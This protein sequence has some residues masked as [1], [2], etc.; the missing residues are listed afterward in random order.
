MGTTPLDIATYVVNPFAVPP[1]LTGA[2]F[3][4]L[5]LTT[6]VRERGSRTSWSFLAV[7]LAGWLWLTCFGFMYLAA[8]SVVAYFWAKAAYLGIPL[9][10]PALYEFA[11]RVLGIRERRRRLVL[12]NWVLFGGF[13]VAFVATDR[14]FGSLHL[15]PW[16]FYP[17]VEPAALAFVLT[18]VGVIGLALSE[19]RRSYRDAETETERLR[20]RALLIAFGVGALALLDY[21]PGFGVEMYPVGFVPALAFLAITANA[22]RRYRLADLTPAFIAERL[23]RTMPDMLIVCDARERIRLVNPAVSRV[24]HHDLDSLKGKPVE[25]LADDDGSLE[26]VRELQR[27]AVAFD[28]QV[29]LRARDGGAV[30]ASVSAAELRDDHGHRVGSMLV[31]RDVRERK[32]MQRELIRRALFDELTGLPNRTLLLERTE[33]ALAHA[34]SRGTHFS[35]VGV[36]IDEFDGIVASVGLESADALLRTVGRRLV[37]ALRESD[38]VAR[39]EGA[40]F[41][42]LLRYVSTVQE[43]VRVI[44]RIRDALGALLEVNGREVHLSASFGIACSRAA[45][46]E[47]GELL[48]DARTALGRARERGRGQ[49]EVFDDRLRSRARRRLALEAE[50]RHALAEGEFEL[51]YQPIVG[52]EDGEVRAWEA[53]LRWRHPERGL[54]EPGRFLATAEDT[55]LMLQIGTATLPRAVRQLATWE[56]TGVTESGRAAVHVNLSPGE[57]GRT[58]LVSGIERVLGETG[59][60]GDR[61]VLELTETTLMERAVRAL[62]T[63]KILRQIGVRFALDDFGTGYSSLAYLHR[64]PVDIVKIDGSFVRGKSGRTDAEIIR[65][66]VELGRSLGI[67]VIAEGIETAEHVALLRELGCRFGQG[68]HLAPPTDPS[69]VTPSLRRRIRAGVGAA[70]SVVRGEE[71]SRG[72]R[73]E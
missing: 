8:D 38:T 72:E 19:L 31:A 69:H 64:F 17:R 60:A 36:E 65:A 22:I 50:L 7:C 23:V 24:L 63:M 18:F 6:L 35:L 12:A 9:I 47:P 52:L 29:T 5:G 39:L 67:Q 41:V 20:A 44:T 2:L 73:T 42:L 55:G 3:L 25:A 1:L 16:G 45:Y 58:G 40:Q 34:R 4:L 15:Y 70:R 62:R 37:A 46:D 53:L 48:R 26:E 57:V 43:A 32:R 61:L 71:A 28:R 30:A 10:A 14:L 11:T 49:V 56:A 51:R 27:R 13:V 68:N 21:L 59:L 54:L 33:G 66:I